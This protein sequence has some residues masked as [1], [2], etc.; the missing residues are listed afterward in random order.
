MSMMMKKMLPFKNKNENEYAQC[1]KIH[2]HI[3]HFMDWQEH[4][5]YVLERVRLI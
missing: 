2:M 5:L 3:E 1:T 4:P